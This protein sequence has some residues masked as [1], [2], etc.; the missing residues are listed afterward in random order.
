MPLTRDILA[1]S[2][3][4]MGVP[5]AGEVVNLIYR[6][7]LVSP[8]YLAEVDAMTDLREIAE[9]LEKLI[10]SWDMEDAPG[11]PFPLETARLMELPLHFLTTLLLAIFKDARP[12]EEQAPDATQTS[13]GSGA[14][15]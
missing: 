11:A 5:Y 15:S 10:V 4:R 3:R 13:A 7:G 1:N 12:G 2:N 14:I 8:Q 6:L 9:R